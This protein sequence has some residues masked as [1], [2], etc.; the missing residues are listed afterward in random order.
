MIV[1][2]DSN[3]AK[4]VKPAESKG[5]SLLV[6]YSKKK[7]TI[8]DDRRAEALNK[9]IQNRPKRSIPSAIDD[10]LKLTEDNPLNK[11]LNLEDVQQVSFRVR[12]SS[13][14]RSKSVDERQ[15]SSYDHLQNSIRSTLLMQ[16]EEEGEGENNKS[17]NALVSTKRDDNQKSPTPEKVNRRQ[18]LANARR[19]NQSMRNLSSHKAMSMRNLS[20]HTTPAAT[21]SPLPTSLNQCRPIPRRIKVPL[22]NEL[23]QTF[24]G[25]LSSNRRASLE[26]LSTKKCSSCRNLIRRSKSQNDSSSKFEESAPLSSITLHT[27]STQSPHRTR[28]T[29]SLRG[30][31]NHT[32]TSRR[33]MLSQSLSRKHLMESSMSNIQNGSFRADDLESS[34]IFATGPRIIRHGATT[35]A[36]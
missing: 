31:K 10:V 2:Q 8:G 32:S 25:Q 27:G 26:H 30:M 22:K 33:H 11:S 7:A 6:D 3:S 24:H 34:M 1:N 20:T 12:K 13:I 35:M 19:K 28:P 9:L 21:L 14:R 18:M 4:T 16:E 23:S 29:A 15:L 5:L 36:P 17:V